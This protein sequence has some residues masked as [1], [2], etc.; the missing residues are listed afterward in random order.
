VDSGVIKAANHSEANIL[1]M[2]NKHFKGDDAIVGNAFCG[3]NKLL[4]KKDHCSDIIE[5]KMLHKT[6]K[7]ECVSKN[8]CTFDLTNKAFFDLNNIKNASKKAT[9]TSIL[10]NS[11]IWL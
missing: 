9:C 6:F 2:K 8:N 11:R 5:D 4:N 10:K 7:K 3:P 1:I